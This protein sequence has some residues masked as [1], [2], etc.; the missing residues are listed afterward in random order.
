[1]KQVG[2]GLVK[3]E[4]APESDSLVIEPRLR[5]TRRVLSAKRK[6]E[7]GHVLYGSNGIS[8]PTAR[9][10]RSTGMRYELFHDSTAVA[11]AVTALAVGCME[12]SSESGRMR[13]LSIL[14]TTEVR[15]SKELICRSRLENAWSS[16]E[17]RWWRSL[18]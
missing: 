7:K 2:S 13:M 8:L 11:V 4:R 6:H 1:V 5:Q 9:R 16:W 12:A 15:T 10:V 14:R 17:S 3:G 18:P